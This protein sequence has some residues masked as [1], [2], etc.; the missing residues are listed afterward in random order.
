MVSRESD[1]PHRLHARSVFIVANAQPH[2]PAICIEFR[3]GRVEDRGEA[4]HSKLDNKDE[5]HKEKHN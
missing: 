3:L 4:I 1:R 5:K 2:R